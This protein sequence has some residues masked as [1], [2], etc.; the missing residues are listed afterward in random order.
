MYC[1]VEFCSFDSETSVLEGLFYGLTDDDSD[2]FFHKPLSKFKTTVDFE[3]FCF[4]FDDYLVYIPGF[5]PNFFRLAV[6]EG[7]YLFLQCF[8]AN[9]V[10]SE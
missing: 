9:E 7:A 8:Y 5:T 3:R 1:A 6:D 10:D 2:V 4:T